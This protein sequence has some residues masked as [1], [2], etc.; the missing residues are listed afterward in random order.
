MT[1]TQ[2]TPTGPDHEATAA[3]LRRGVAGWLPSMAAAEFLIESGF[4]GKAVS[5]GV[6]VRDPAPER[7]HRAY[8]TFPDDWQ[9]HTGYL[10]GG[11]QAAL[12]L[13]AALHNGVLGDEFFRMGHHG[14]RAFVTA[15]DG[16]IER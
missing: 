13:A 11:E 10:S 2:S 12:R 3:A 15:L 5:A 8:L 9:D 4:L 1:N 14:R 7:G 16:V 6:V